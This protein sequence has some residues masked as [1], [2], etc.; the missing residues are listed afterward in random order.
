VCIDRIVEKARRLEHTLPVFGARHEF[1]DQNT[2]FVILCLLQTAPKRLKVLILE[3]R[4]TDTHTHTH[5][6][7]HTH[8]RITYEAIQKFDADSLHRIH[9]KSLAPTCHAFAVRQA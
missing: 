8:A 9:F 2:V 6:Y 3:W 5:T 1:V 4:H 7:T